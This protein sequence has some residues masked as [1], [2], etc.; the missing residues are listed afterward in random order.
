[1]AHHVKDQTLSLLWRRLLLWYEFNPWPENFCMLQTLPKK[2]KEIITKFQST[3]PWQALGN[4]L[5]GGCT[6]P[7]H[8]KWLLSP[9]LTRSHQP[10]HHQP[11][12]LCPD[13]PCSPPTQTFIV[14]P[15][16]WLHKKQT[17]LHSHSF[18]VPCIFKPF[19]ALPYRQWVS[20]NSAA[21]KL[22]LNVLQS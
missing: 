3:K 11:A 9:I 20:S 5:W 17:I 2:K 16:P 1:M 4:F 21:W 13:I 7:I 14:P 10:F 15:V 8:Q 19:L 18:P 12:V 22:Q 6:F